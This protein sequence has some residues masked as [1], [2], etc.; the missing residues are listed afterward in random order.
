MIF[1]MKVA[2]FNLRYSPNLGDG[3][4][5][6]CLEKELRTDSPIT[7]TF[8][9]DLA[10][11]RAYS[12]GSTY[13]RF[14]LWL[15]QALPGWLRRIVVRTM[16]E[17]LLRHELLPHWRAALSEADAV[18]VGGGN[19]F[20]DTDLNFPLKVNGALTE[21][22]R[23]GL[24][25]AVYGVGVTPNW[26]PLGARLFAGPLAAGRT[27]DASVRDE[28]SRES[29]QRLMVPQGV[30]NAR[31]VCDPGLLAADHFP[32]AP[33]PPRSLP[34]HIGIGVIDP[35]V[36]RYHGGDTLSRRSF[37]DR[38]HSVIVELLRVPCRISLFSNGSPEDRSFL[39]SLERRF[40]GANLP[41]VVIAPPFAAPAELAGFVSGCD[42]VLAHRMH[43]C[44]AAYSYR[45]PTIGFTWD[46]KMRSFFDLVRRPEYLV[47]FSTITPAAL[48]TLAEHALREGI[49]PAIHADLLARCRDG[50]ARLRA[51]L[52]ETAAPVGRPAAG[53]SGGR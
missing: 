13:R 51:V 46:D 30:R 33:R 12:S 43:A 10:G 41:G 47:D 39:A 11:R 14:Q 1:E 34:P 3:L 52:A 35:V 21:T 28:Q 31:L 4:L 19:L 22:N 38:L 48:A 9:L 27:V 20:A 2:L 50:I 44:V 36:L 37:G 15:L 26:T 45:V 5:S 23:R 8:S 16:L 25:I 32:P 7:E 24:P 6:E 42:L 18:V 17:R 29:W 53:L 49:D 40:A